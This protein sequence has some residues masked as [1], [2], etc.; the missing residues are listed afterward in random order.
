M[1]ETPQTKR[2]ARMG[3]DYTKEM[4][5]AYRKEQDEKAKKE[6]EASRERAEKESARREWISDG[7]TEADF[8]RDWPRIRDE[9]RKWRVVDA[10]VDA[11]QRARKAH[12]AI[13][14]SRI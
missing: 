4:H 7:G 10:V 12:R 6:E 13:G 2:D 8:E 11:D 1:L 5:E 14:I 9:G 3:K